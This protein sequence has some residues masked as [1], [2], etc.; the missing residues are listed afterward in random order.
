VSCTKGASLLFSRV[1]SSPRDLAAALAA[2]I[3]AA[4]AETSRGPVSPEPEPDAEI[5]HVR[6]A[7]KRS[8]AHVTPQVPASAPFSTA[9]RAAIRLLRFAWRD[10]SSY[11][12]LMLEAAGEIAGAVAEARSRSKEKAASL[13]AE[14]VRLE[15]KFE[16]WMDAVEA[17][18]E[19][20]ERREAI[21][22]GR[23]AALEAAAG[24]G[25]EST[26]ASATAPSIPPGVYSLFEERFRGRPDD[27]ERKQRSYVPFLRSLPGPVLDA[28][29]GRGEFLSLLRREGIPASGVESNP[30][31]VE[32]CR[33]AGLE[34]FAGDVVADLA[35]REPGRL[36]AVTA[37]QVVEHWPPE[38]VFAFL[39]SARRAIAPGGVLIAETINTDSLS[40]LK[41]FFLDP[42]H[43]RPVPAEALHFLA[44]AAGFIDARIEYRGQLPDAER[45]TETDENDRR[46]NRLL[47]GPQDYAVVAR[48]PQP[49]DG[50]RETGNVSE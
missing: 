31:A 45:L 21:R 24:G 35:A 38:V 26:A 2:E 6:S 42:T 22:D 29:C 7:L 3:R 13:A 34:V 27:V 1:V 46:L 44:G 30:L 40:A 47:F 25:A 12:A 48:V 23:L 33:A 50:K 16:R 49:G 36:G 8:E 37:F 5:E 28:G 15:R 4:I 9:K 19:G 39:R 17:W 41:A 14:L 20:E 18:R 11:N 43:V 10:Q 32:A